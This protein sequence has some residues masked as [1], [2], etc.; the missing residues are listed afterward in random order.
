MSV[1]VIALDGG[2]MSGLDELTGASPAFVNAMVMG[3]P[4]SPPP[5]AIV[6]RPGIAAW[7]DF[8]SGVSSSPVVAMEILGGKVI[9][10]TD[11]GAGTRKAFGIDGTTCTDMSFASGDSLVN[12]A[13]SVTLASWR[14]FA[15]VSGGS[16]VQKLSRGF[17]STRLGGSPPEAADLCVIAQ[18]LV[19]VS[20][21]EFG[22]FFWNSLPGE[23][24]VEGWDQ[25]LDF[26]EAEAR[27]DRLIACK[28][29]TR[30]L[31]MFGE[32]TLQVF[33]P[34]ES[35]IFAPAAA[36]D[37]GCVAKR[38]V[39]RVD[40]NM[41]WLA[42]KSRIVVSDGR[43]F[44]VISDLG[45]SGTLKGIATTSDAWAFRCAIGAH[46]ILAWVFPTDG[47]TFAF[48]QKAKVWSEW[49]RKDTSGRWQPWAPTSYLY[50][51]SLRK[52]LVGM[53]DGT[54]AELTLDAHTDLG[55]P[56]S[57]VVRTGFKEVTKRRHA[58]E[59]RF[60]CRRG[61]ASSEGSSIAI[62]WRNDL[63]AFTPAIECPLGIPGD[64]EADV[65][66][67]PCG[68]PY[69]RRQ[70]ELSGSADD[71]YLIAGGKETYEDAEF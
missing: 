67:S 69:R 19:I 33:S 14:E 29:G 8:P 49:R 52:H 71:A 37:I 13:S 39:V 6:S 21:D 50:S 15:F 25:S 48:D 2:Q 18:R 54:I 45:I 20:P 24:S 26:R 7:A 41:A 43:G 44:D 23:A 51:E 55:D 32:S 10:V 30:E 46:D 58:V 40:Q 27:P 11:D 28:E 63:G 34:D 61:S 56:I 5:R 60:P 4:G 12:G 59:A 36:L 66:V 1:D 62:R 38:G 57:W 53:P 3:P 47:R 65:A 31:F 70:W 64:Y 68:E 16:A 17:V 42:D 9:F 22:L 35:E